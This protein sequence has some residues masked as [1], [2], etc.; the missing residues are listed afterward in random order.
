M[1]EQASNDA[2]IWF[3]NNFMKAN[4]SKFQSI[5]FNKDD[6]SLN[7]EVADSTIKSEKVVKLLG[8]QLDSK[9]SFT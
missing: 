3:G 4:P 6:L 7:F 9:L 2:L 1:L 8:I 5:W